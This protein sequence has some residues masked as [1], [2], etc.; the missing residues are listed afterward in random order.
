MPPQTNWH[1]QMTGAIASPHAA[2]K[3]P[4][5]MDIGSVFFLKNS[6]S[7]LDVVYGGLILNEKHNRQSCESS[8]RVGLKLC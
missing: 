1:T 5:S 3:V 8:T 2:P 7:L 6:L 4:E